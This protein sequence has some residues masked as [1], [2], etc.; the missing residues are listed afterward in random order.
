MAGVF[1]G[2]TVLITGGGAGL[3]RAAAV[4][5]AREGARVALVDVSEEGLTASA[6]AVAGPRPGPR[7]SGSSLTSPRRTRSGRTWT[8]P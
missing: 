2:R 1:D 6:S 3:G 5:V 8:R 7:L 4:R